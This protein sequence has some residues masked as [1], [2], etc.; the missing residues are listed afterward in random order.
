MGIAHDL[1]KFPTAYICT[2]TIYVRSKY[3]AMYYNY[4]VQYC[5]K[6]YFK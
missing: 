2:C 5:D 4:Q 6:S 3:V 1:V